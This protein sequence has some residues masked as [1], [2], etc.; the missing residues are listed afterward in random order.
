[1]SGSPETGTFGYE[2]DLNLLTGEEK[3]EIREQIRDYKKYWHLIHSGSYYRLHDPE[4]DTEAAAGYC[5]SGV[6]MICDI[7]SSLFLKYCLL[8]IISVYPKRRIIAFKLY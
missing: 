5:T 7:K 3:E 8:R 2:L 4:C 1:M 6:W